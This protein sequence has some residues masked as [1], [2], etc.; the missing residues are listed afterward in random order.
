MDQQTTD[1]MSVIYKLFY[2]F[3]SICGFPQYPP[4]SS[5]ISKSQGHTERTAESWRLPIPHCKMH[6][7]ATAPGRTRRLVE[8]R[9]R[10]YA[11][12]ASQFLQ[13]LKVTQRGKGCLGHGAGE[14]KY[15]M[16]RIEIQP[17]H[18]T[19]E[20]NQLGIHGTPPWHS[21]K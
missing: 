14:I 20:R 13:S 18:L 21:S 17:L 6:H 16:E 12:A 5:G 15:L 10:T 3:K 9:F 2:R 19:T 1:K 7:R 11:S 4:E 8:P